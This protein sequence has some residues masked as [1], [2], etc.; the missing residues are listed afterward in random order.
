[1]KKPNQRPERMAVL[2]TAIGPSLN[3]GQTKMSSFEIVHT[4]TD[5]YDGPRGGVADFR[6]RPHAYA[7]LFEKSGVYSDTFLLM[8]IQEELFRLA[9]EDWEIWLRWERAF[10]AGE[11]TQE[12]HPALPPDRARHDEISRLIGD[13]LA[14]KP[15]LSQRARAEFRYPSEQLLEVCWFPREEEPNQLPEPMPHTRHG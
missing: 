4:M 13:R 14:P 2:R 5:F 12:T 10:Y 7:S 9:L 6:G 15:E 1:M 3:G 8:P 11:A